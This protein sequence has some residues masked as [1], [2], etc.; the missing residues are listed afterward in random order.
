[1]RSALAIHCFTQRYKAE[2][3]DMFYEKTTRVQFASFNLIR[4]N[5]VPSYSFTE[6]DPAAEQSLNEKRYRVDVKISNVS[7]TF[8]TVCQVNGN[9]QLQNCLIDAMTVN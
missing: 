9:K 5:Q 6:I 7:M 4:I 1:M 2:Q 3:G 8:Q